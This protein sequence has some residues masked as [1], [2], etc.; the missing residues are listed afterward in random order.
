[1]KELSVLFTIYCLC[2]GLLIACTKVVSTPTP[3]ID[4]GRLSTTMSF[5]DR[6]VF[7]G[8]NLTFSVKGTVGSK[9]SIQITDIAGDVKL[10]QGITVDEEVEKVVMPLNKLEMGIYDIIFLDIKGNNIKQP[11]IKK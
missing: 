8:G 6:P 9:Y 10:I 1:M 2:V 11:L 3:S 4:L 5:V 7:V